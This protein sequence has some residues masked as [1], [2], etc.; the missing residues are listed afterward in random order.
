MEQCF[1]IIAKNEAALMLTERECGS[2]AVFC[3][4]KDPTS[5]T[6]D[7]LCLGQKS[8][9]PFTPTNLL[10]TGG[11]WEQPG[12][13]LDAESADHTERLSPPCLCCGMGWKSHQSV[14]GFCSFRLCCSFCCLSDE[15]LLCFLW[16]TVYS[17][18]TKR[19]LHNSLNSLGLF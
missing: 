5:R 11:T 2:W 3:P 9:C 10:R 18:V 17:Y 16:K 4:E 8:T 1:Q 7:G 12:A 13:G 14:D 19:L 6:A 15:V